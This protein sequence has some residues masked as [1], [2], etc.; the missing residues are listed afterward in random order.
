MSPSPN[1]SLRVLKSFAAPD[2]HNYVVLLP[3]FLLFL[4]IVSCLV[5]IYSTES[6][7]V[8][9]LP[10]IPSIL[11]RFV[12]VH[13]Q[14]VP[15]LLTTGSNAMETGTSSITPLAKHENFIEKV[16]RAYYHLYVHICLK[17][18]FAGMDILL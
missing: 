15:Y 9:H 17:R 7:A 4:L 13:Y 1:T 18:C 2:I 10:N 12:D 14:L 5:F 8:L 6:F 3:C 11:H 16:G